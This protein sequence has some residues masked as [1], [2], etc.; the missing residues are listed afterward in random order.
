[1][2]VYQINVTATDSNEL[3]ASL[4]FPYEVVG[5]LQI[6]GP[7][8]A[9]TVTDVGRP[10]S[11]NAVPVGGAG[12]YRYLWSGLPAG[13]ASTLALLDC[14]PTAAGRYVVN[15]TVTDA[16]GASAWGTPVNVTVNTA[17]TATLS[18]SPS[19][20]ILGDE[21]T[22]RAVLSGG[23]AGYSFAWS[24]LPAGC[25]AVNASLL[26]CDPSASG[27]SDVTVR[28]TDAAGAQANATARVT[29]GSAFL[30]LPA[31]E[32]YAVV[33]GIA[34]LAIVGAVLAFRRPGRTTESTRRPA[35]GRAERPE[36]DG[37]EPVRP[38]MEP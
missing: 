4:S 1:M 30:G 6:E 24:G 12:G 14:Q 8:A 18:V 9:T 27:T 3:S 13:C 15:L 20:A 32:G 17:P 34:A 38:R 19:G 31:L 28:V 11:L 21:I 16:N 25:L 5:L 35:E 2:G 37:P 33:G 7:Y 23:T 36:T 10:L 29:V 26:R 22:L